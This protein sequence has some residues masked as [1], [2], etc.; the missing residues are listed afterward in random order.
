MLFGGHID[1]HDYHLVGLNEE[2]LTGFLIACGYVKIRRVPELGL[3]DD[4]S[5]MSFKGVPISLNMI[6][7]KRDAAASNGDSTVKETGRNQACPCGSGR[8]FKYCHG[9]LA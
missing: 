3:F 8:K 9:K 6:A 2:F 1:K 7:E 4:T 5:R